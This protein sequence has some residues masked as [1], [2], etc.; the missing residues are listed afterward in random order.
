VK[1]GG[2]SPLIIMSV[3]WGKRLI[4]VVTHTR[5]YTDQEC[6]F[7]GEHVQDGVFWIEEDHVCVT[8]SPYSTGHIMCVPDF[9][10]FTTNLL[11][12]FCP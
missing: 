5:T 3:R 7:C 9:R 6:R 2:A 11:Y 1:E 8:G 12:G 4:E 10:A